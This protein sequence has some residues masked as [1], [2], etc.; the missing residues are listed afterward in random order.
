MKLDIEY[1]IKLESVINICCHL[2]LFPI[3]YFKKVGEV[4]DRIKTNT[5]GIDDIDGLKIAIDML[6]NHKEVNDMLR[7]DLNDTKLYLE[8]KVA[9]F[10]YI[11]QSTCLKIIN[12]L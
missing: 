5:L 9:E 1:L 8:I 12:I 4:L 7:T 6:I 3:Q 11:P 2:C 10:A